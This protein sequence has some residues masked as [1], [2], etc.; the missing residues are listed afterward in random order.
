MPDKSRPITDITVSGLL[1]ALKPAQLWILIAVIFA[2]I[3]GAFGLGYKANALK[4]EVEIAKYQNEIATLKMQTKQFLG[5]TTKERFLSAYL[6]YMLAKRDH[7]LSPSDQTQETLKE[8]MTQFRAYIQ[9]LLERGEKAR[10]E[11]D[12]RGL[13]LGK[14][15]GKMANVKFAYD[16]SVWPV[17][18]EF[19]F[20]AA[21]NDLVIR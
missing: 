5:L 11:I 20:F 8:I 12:L 15:A 1:G 4:T 16:G 6:K 17:P 10:D 21:G 19:G 9:S 7:Q 13:F 2:L 3:S 18:P 14:G